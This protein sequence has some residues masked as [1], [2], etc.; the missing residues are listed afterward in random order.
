V[1]IFLIS[2]GTDRFIGS[3]I[4]NRFGD[5][6]LKFFKLFGETSGMVGFIGI[7]RHPEM[8]EYPDITNSLNSRDRK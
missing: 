4:N 1:K 6:A 8:L 5:F 7:S 3:T 2:L